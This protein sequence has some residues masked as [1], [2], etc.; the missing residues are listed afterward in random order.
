VLAKYLRTFEQIVKLYYA[1]LSGSFLWRWP[2][3]RRLYVIA[4][5]G[6]VTVRIRF[7]AKVGGCG[8][9]FRVFV[10]SPLTRV[11]LVAEIT[12]FV[13]DGGIFID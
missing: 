5:A 1:F 2:S 8:G 3:R 9:R 11:G 13:N 7:A 4:L 6:Q 12:F 10:R